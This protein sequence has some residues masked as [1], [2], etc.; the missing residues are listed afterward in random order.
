MY[1]FWYIK[2]TTGNK[3]VSVGLSCPGLRYCS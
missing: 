1:T 3:A 2:R